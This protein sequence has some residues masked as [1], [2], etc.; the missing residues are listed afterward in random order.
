MQNMEFH[1]TNLK[2]F[3]DETNTNIVFCF[4][5]SIETF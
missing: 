3:T 4:T 1:P 5:V 2:L